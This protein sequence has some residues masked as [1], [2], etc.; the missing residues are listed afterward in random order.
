MTTTDQNKRTIV[1]LID[2]LFSNGDISAVDDHVD[3]A[4]IFHDPPFGLTSDKAG[5]VGAAK[6]MREAC[7]DW[8]SDVQHLVAEGDFVA[9]HFIAKGTHTGADLMGVPPSG[10]VITLAGFQLFR[11]DGGQV[12]ERWGRIDELGVLGQL[13]LLPE[14]TP[15]PTA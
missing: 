6:V 11:M 9:E 2:R 14:A 15:S 1:D 10:R 3:D 5:M 13:G 8:R 4:F 7:S 12:V